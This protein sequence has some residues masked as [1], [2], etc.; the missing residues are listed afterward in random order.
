MARIFSRERLDGAA[1]NGQIGRPF[2]G[3]VLGS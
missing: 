3:E 1:R 2:V